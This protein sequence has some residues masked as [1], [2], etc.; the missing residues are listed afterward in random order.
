MR[1]REKLENL[2]PLN[3]SDLALGSPGVILENRPAFVSTEKREVRD[4]LGRK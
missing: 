3:S 1:R 2:D 4:F